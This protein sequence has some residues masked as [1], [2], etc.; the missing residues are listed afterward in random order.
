MKLTFLAVIAA[1]LW[2]PACFSQ[3][4]PSNAMNL[5]VRNSP[6]AVNSRPDAKSLPIRQFRLARGQKLKDSR[7]TLRNSTAD[8][9]ACFEPDAWGYC[10][11]YLEYFGSFNFAYENFGGFSSYAIEAAQIVNIQGERVTTVCIDGVCGEFADIDRRAI[12]NIPQ[13]ATLQHETRE[14]LGAEILDF[15]LLSDIDFKRKKKGDVRC[16]LTGSS[17]R[18][19]TQRHDYTDRWLAVEAVL[20]S[21][22]LSDRASVI[23]ASGI[24]QV[25]F[26]DGGVED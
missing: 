23:S 4:N 15:A 5:P 22:R 12:M 20:R 7:L 25:T 3:G 8:S 16:A 13:V 19:V 11:W 26:A 18:Q 14:A 17:L 21:I 6:P 10:A 9:G 24:L 1:A 2:S